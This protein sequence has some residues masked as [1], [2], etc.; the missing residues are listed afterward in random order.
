M[1]RWNHNVPWHWNLL[2]VA[3]FVGVLVL[4][5]ALEAR[6]RRWRSGQCEKPYGGDKMG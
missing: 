2:G 6:I 5:L 3:M 4:W 1:Y